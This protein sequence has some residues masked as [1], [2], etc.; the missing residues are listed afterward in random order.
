MLAMNV[1]LFCDKITVLD[2]AYYDKAKGLVG[3]SYY[4]NVEF[5]G[6]TDEEGILI[7]FSHAKKQVKSVIDEICDHRFVLPKGLAQITGDQ[8]Q[9]EYNFGS[10][11]RSL[12]YSGPL[13]ALCEIPY[14]YVSKENI[15]CFLED[16][17]NKHFGLK[18]DQI[19]ITLDDEVLPNKPILS[20]THG[21]KQ[22]YGNCQRLFHGHKNSVDIWVNGEVKPELESYLI[23]DCFKANIHFCLKENIVNIEEVEKSLPDQKYGI[24]SSCPFVEIKY[25]SSQGEFRSVLPSE[26]VYVLEQESTVENLSSHF[27][28]ILRE[29]IGGNEKIKVKAYEGIAKGAIS[30]I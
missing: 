12:F 3:D 11:S 1:S 2:I 15:A 13:Q 29:K 14:Q 8:F 16:E 7:D 26:M 6:N 22:H 27:A 4:V 30:Y 20:Y 23:R 19:K 17:L 18:F 10:E 25:S 5:L 9:L 21:L 28:H 24:P